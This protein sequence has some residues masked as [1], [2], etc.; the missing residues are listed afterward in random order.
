[1]CVSKRTYM[2]LSRRKIAITV[3][4]SIYKCPTCIII[5]CF[6]VI[7]SRSILMMIPEL[8]CDLHYTNNKF[9]PLLAYIRKATFLPISKILSV[10]KLNSLFLY[11]YSSCSVPGREALSWVGCL[12]SSL[13]TFPGYG[14]EGNSANAWQ[15]GTKYLHHLDSSRTCFQYVTTPLFPTDFELEIS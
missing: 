10:T 9:L 5:L 8:N 7:R 11:L 15:K 2:T 13:G 12:W 6:S 4:F 1:M 3:T 14:W